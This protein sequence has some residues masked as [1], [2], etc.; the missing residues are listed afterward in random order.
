MALVLDDYRIAVLIETKGVDSSPVFRAS[1]VFS[2]EESN[3]E[4]L[5]KVRLNRRLKALLVRRMAEVRLDLSG[6][7]GHEPKEGHNATLRRRSAGRDRPG[8]QTERRARISAHD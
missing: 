5:V 4:H 3:A 7:A 6:L 8:R 2:C 1:P